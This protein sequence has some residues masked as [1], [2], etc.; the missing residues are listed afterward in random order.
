MPQPG[1]VINFLD[2][3]K[4]SLEETRKKPPAQSLK[5]ETRKAKKRKRA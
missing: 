4:E 3:L 2:A 1:K 5:A